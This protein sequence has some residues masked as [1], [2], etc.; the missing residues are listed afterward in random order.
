MFCHKCGTELFEGEFCPNCG[1]KIIKSATIAWDLETKEPVTPIKNFESDDCNNQ[2]TNNEREEEVAVDDS[3]VNTIKTK[4][5]T[6]LSG[7]IRFIVFLICAA[8]IL[9][10]IAGLLA[11]AYLPAGCLAASMIFFWRFGSIVR[12]PKKALKGLAISIGLFVLF[13]IWLALI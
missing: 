1:Q 10:S 4:L 2:I 7:I 13:I 12:K 3:E 11:G 5:I 9:V 8:G 6:V